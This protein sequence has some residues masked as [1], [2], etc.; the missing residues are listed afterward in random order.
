MNQVKAVKFVLLW[1]QEKSLYH[2]KIIDFWK[3][4]QALPANTAAEDRLKEVVYVAVSQGE[5]IGVNTAIEAKVPHLSNGLFM[6]YRIL[7]HPKFR[8][9][10]LVDKMGVLT[11]QYFDQLYQTGAIRSLGVITLIENQ[12]YKE[13]RREAVWPSTGLTYVGDSAAGHHIRLRYFE[14]AKF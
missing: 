11:I 5:I 3:K 10:G 13:N 1:D 14:G 6:N 4:L 7:I 12:W 9:P 2:E 8:I